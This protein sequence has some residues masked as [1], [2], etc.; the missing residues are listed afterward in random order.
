MGHGTGFDIFIVRWP[1]F[2]DVTGEGLLLLPKDRKP[3]ADVIAIP[4][5]GQTPEQLV[6]L[7]PG[8]PRNRNLPAD[9]RKV[10]V[11]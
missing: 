4:D 10:V 2:G 6:G 7:V 5:C 3:V 11:A 8:V 1:A 9:S